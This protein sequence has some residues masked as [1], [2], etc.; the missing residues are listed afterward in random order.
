MKFFHRVANSH[1][2]NHAIK[3]LSIDGFASSNQPVIKDHLA[4][5]FEELLL[6]PFDWRPRLNGLDFEAIDQTS[7]VWLERP[8]EE[9]V[10]QV[11]RKM[12]RDKAPSSDGF[13]MAF[14]Q[15]FWEVVKEDVMQ[16]FQEFFTFGKFEK[17]LNATFIALVPKKVGAMEVKDFCPIS[18]VGSMYKI[19]SKVLANRMSMDMWFWGEMEIVDEALCV[20]VRFSIL[21]NGDPVGFF[22]S[23]RGLCQVSGLKV[24]LTKSELVAVDNIRNVR[25]LASILGCGVS[26]LSMKYLSLQSQD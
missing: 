11:V 26:S 10:Q 21:V 1:K 25:G 20:K 14:F 12:N 22:N 8:F 16:V 5:H 6:E 19:L 2:R 18:L 3:S 24:N 7:I 13:T 9:E 15:T 17:C 23:L 4:G